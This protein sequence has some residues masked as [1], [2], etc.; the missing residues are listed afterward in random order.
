MCEGEKQGYSE[1]EEEE[2]SLKIL[3][4]L[5][6]EEFTTRPL[7]ERYDLLM[8]YVKDAEHQIAREE[9]PLLF[10]EWYLTRDAEEENGKE[11]D[12]E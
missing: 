5:A 11:P 12:G 7:E 3:G 6:W 1:N 2:M 9:L 10:L 8:T 4:G